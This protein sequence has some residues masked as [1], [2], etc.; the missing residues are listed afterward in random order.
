MNRVT[1]AI[2]AL[3]SAASMLY[4]Q[5]LQ[6]RDNNQTQVQSVEARPDY[7]I[8]NLSSRN[9]NAEG[10][11]D[12]SVTAV[13]MEHFDTSNMTFFTQPVYLVYP[14]KGTT[15]WRLSAETGHL[16]KNTSK[17]ILKDN[18]VIDAISPSDPIQSLSTSKLELDLD[19]MIMTS[20]EAISIKGDN[21]SIQGK[22]LYAD[23]N[24]QQVEL[25]SQVEGKYETN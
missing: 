10:L 11:L 5:V 17:V 20:D 13:H 12:S 19:T 4:W 23:L 25:L 18:V 16:N 6:K 24:T 9:Y 15:Q 14:N 1:L 22:G 7:V 8:S 2:I 3:F 21:F